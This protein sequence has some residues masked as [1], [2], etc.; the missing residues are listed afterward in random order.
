[1]INIITAISNPDVNLFEGAIKRYSSFFNLGLDFNW[2]IQFHSSS[3]IDEFNIESYP[4]I[5]FDIADDRSIYDAWNLALKRIKTGN[6]IFLGL[7]D[8]P[9]FEFLLDA[10]KI[11]LSELDLLSTDVKMQSLDS[12]FSYTRSN[13]KLGKVSLYKFTYCHP[14]LVFS[15]LLFANKSF[16]ENYKIISDGLFYSKIPFLNVVGYF[17]S[18]GVTM[19]VGGISNSRKGARSRFIELLRALYVGD[20]DLNRFQLIG[21]LKSFPAYIL[22][23]FPSFLFKFFQKTRWMLSSYF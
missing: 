2:I 17:P 14:G 23:F 10:S 20:M 8:I 19:L 18:S 22:S 11:M 15:H 4:F 21:L 3:Q 1:M 16:N 13:P 5:S 9:N 6:V 7:D 12:K